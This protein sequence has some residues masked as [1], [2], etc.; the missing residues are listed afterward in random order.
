VAGLANKHLNLVPNRLHELFSEIRDQIPVAE[1]LFDV[2]IFPADQAQELVESAREIMVVRNLYE[3]D[4]NKDLENQQSKLRQENSALKVES[5]RDALTGVYN[6]RA[7]EDAV[8]REF[9][10]ASRS[11]WP[12][13]VIFVD[14]DHFNGINDTH[15][16]QGGDAM[17]KAVAGLLSGTLRDSDV[18]ARYGGDE[19]VLLLPGVDANQV[20]AV[21]D[22]LV[23]RAREARVDNGSGA[24]FSVTLSL[25]IATRDARSTFGSSQD[26]LAAADAALY[27]SKR[28]GRNQHTSYDRIKAA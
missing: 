18:V 22:R 1:G 28:N 11:S 24:S 3:I 25:G 16:H 27:H 26:L 10:A 9:S 20:E 6:R 13:S 14:I 2:E 7:F 17:L 23:R 12:L 4:R 15:G 21:A 5:E 19:F 8:E